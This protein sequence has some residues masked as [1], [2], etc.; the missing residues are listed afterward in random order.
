VLQF[1]D[2]TD[3]RSFQIFDLVDPLRFAGGKG[4]SEPKIGF[5]LSYEPIEQRIF[6]TTHPSS[7]AVGRSLAFFVKQSHLIGSSV[8]KI[9]ADTCASYK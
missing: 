7:V 6:A 9:W 8:F 4:L 5:C 1:G 2:L 3:Q